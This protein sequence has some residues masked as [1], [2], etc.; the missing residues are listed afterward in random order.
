MIASQ[1]HIYIRKRLEEK[2]VINLKEIAAE[3]NISEITVR[4]DFEKLENLGYLRRVQGGAILE[5]SY[6]E[7][8]I[9]MSE[10]KNI[11]ISEKIRVAKFAAEL[12]NDGD[13]VFI[14][15]GTSIAEIAKIL[16]NKKVSIVTNSEYVVQN[17]YKPTVATIYMVGGKFIPAYSMFA[18]PYAEE[19]LKYYHCDI[20]FFGCT[21]VEIDRKIAYEAE[22]ES[23][24]MKRIA[25]ENTRKSYLIIDNSKLHR[26]SFIEFQS[27]DKF[28]KVICNKTEEVIDLGDTDNFIFI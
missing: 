4:R 27:T 1:R 19:V 3:L 12:V 14:D 8:E 25:F 18:G 26:R 6:E 17:I 9:S 22:T 15:A 10:K 20:G 13:S 2:G 21:S 5:S 24:A 23:L 11:N 28:E 16:L 7:A